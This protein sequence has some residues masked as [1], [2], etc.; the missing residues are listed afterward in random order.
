MPGM[1]NGQVDVGL[2]PSEEDGP[3]LSVWKPSGHSCEL[4]HGTG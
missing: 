1:L 3:E 4:C 2:E